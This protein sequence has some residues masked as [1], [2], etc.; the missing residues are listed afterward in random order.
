MKHTPGPWKYAVV[1]ERS[2][3][4]TLDDGYGYVW[5]EP[6]GQTI[7]EV[8]KSSDT[9]AN[10]RLIAAAPDLLAALGYMVRAT[11]VTQ[12][13]PIVMFASIEKARAAIQK[14]TGEA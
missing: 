8:R 12:I 3:P 11:N 1:R 7:A 2:G 5:P 14:A 10:A 4:N 6:T 9:E 13:D